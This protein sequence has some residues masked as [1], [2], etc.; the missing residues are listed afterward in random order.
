M[1][2]CS[3]KAANIAEARRVISEAVGQGAEVVVLPEIWN[4]PYSNASFPSSAEDVEGGLSPSVDMLSSAAREHGIVLIGGSI[5]ERSGD[6]VYNTCFVFG[7]DGQR[8][9]RH[10]K[11][12]LFDID[13]PGQMTFR[14]S[15]TLSAGE[16]LTVVDTPFG[17]LGIG[18]CYD[19]RF[20][21]MAA[22]YAARGCQ[23]LVYPGAFSTATG[24][25]YWEL[26]ARARAQDNQLFVA[27][28]SPARDGASGY[29]AWGHSSLVDPRGVVVATTEHA[30]AVVLARVDLSMVETQRR[31]IPIS[32]QKRADLYALVDRTRSE[33]GAAASAGAV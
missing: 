22:L 16:G 13:I 20:P 11:T 1:A 12:H 7:R 18:I 24:P 33:A 29:V 8:L 23:L 21:E 17:R 26:L 9:G 27:V 25:L 28:V 19:I 32:F 3:N 2:V 31:N 4:S 30:P 10:R 15:E 14:E 5:P 6:R